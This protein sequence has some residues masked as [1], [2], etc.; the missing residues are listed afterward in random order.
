[1]EGVP[2]GVV[3]RVQK[4][5]RTRKSRCTEKYK[6][7]FHVWVNS[8]T[9]LCMMYVNFMAVCLRLL[10]GEK[11]RRVLPPQPLLS[12]P[13]TCGPIKCPTFSSWQRGNL[14]SAS[15]LGMGRPSSPEP[16]NDDS[17][18][19]PMQGSPMSPDNDRNVE[20]RL[21]PNLRKTRQLFKE[22]IEKDEVSAQSRMYLFSE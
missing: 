19:P 22:V 1:M 20:L 10:V 21:P 5:W 11:K 12:T 3:F 13:S 17:Q 7:Y 15:P 14:G 2:G 16:K 8:W 18:S 4:C 6:K 9:D